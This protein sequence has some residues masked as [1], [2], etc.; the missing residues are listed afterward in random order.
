MNTENIDNIDGN[1]NENK[2]NKLTNLQIYGFMLLFLTTGSINTIANKLQQNTTSK[3][4]KKPKVDA[5]EVEAVEVHDL[6]GD[7]PSMSL[8]E[9]IDSDKNIRLAVDEL[10]AQNVTPN[11]DNIKAKLLDLN[12]MGKVTLDEY[13]KAKELLE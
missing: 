11:R 4:P 2:S 6:S 10:Q 9:I 8:K 12:E 1:K 7:K 5:I 3:A 13:K